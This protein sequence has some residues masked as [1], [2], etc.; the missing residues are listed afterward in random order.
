MSRALTGG[1]MPKFSQRFV[2]SEE[3]ADAS[4]LKNVFYQVMADYSQSYQRVQDAKPPRQPHMRYGH[5]GTFDVYKAKL[6]WL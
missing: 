2:D 6:L 1:L 3:D 4:N 5:V